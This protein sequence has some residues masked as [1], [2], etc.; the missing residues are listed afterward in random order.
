MTTLCFVV[1]FI[2]AFNITVFLYQA[3]NITVS[4]EKISLTTAQCL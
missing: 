1:F 4:V 2:H 3:F